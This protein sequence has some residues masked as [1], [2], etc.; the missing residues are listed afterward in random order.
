MTNKTGSTIDRTDPWPAALRLL[1]G[2]DYSLAEL[3]RR[4]LDKGF[5]PAGVDRALQRC[6][7]FGYLDDARYAL[8]RATSLMTQGRAVGPRILVDLR[9]RGIS[10]EVAC[11]ALTRAREACDEDELLA[12]LLHRRFPDF[13]YNTAPAREQRRVVHFL[14]RRGF[15]IG[16]IMDRLTRKGFETND[17]DR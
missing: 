8:N 11:Q 1:T 12:S 10:E 13:S 14:Q 6:L 5:A 7:E 16:H 4:L 9:Q 17:E 15:T 2:R 3:R